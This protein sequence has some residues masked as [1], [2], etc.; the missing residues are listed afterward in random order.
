[1]RR[2]PG[3]GK[4]DS[5]MRL[6]IQSEDDAFRSVLAGAVMVGVCWL[7]GYLTSPLIG[8]VLACAVVPLA[9]VWAAARGAPSSSLGEA[10]E[11][12][13]LRD[14]PPRLLL[15][16]TQTPTRRQLR[17]EVFGHSGARPMVEVHSPVLQSR[18]HFVTTDIDTETE[19]ARQRLQTILRA[20][21]SEGVTAE[22]HVGD[23]IDPIAGVQDE[24]RRHPA[25]EVILTTHD[26][27]NANW[28]ES[29]LLQRLPAELHKPVI[30]I[31]VDENVQP[32]QPM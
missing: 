31:V 10:E 28:V 20:A 26:D 27:A 23:P 7:I 8:I 25:D 6:P 13:K 22:G 14:E 11:S 1:M 24:L 19:Q 4:R 29:E 2:D 16:A 21:R 17:E 5:T 15:I 30:Q 3:R 12:A 9:L 18:T 32:T